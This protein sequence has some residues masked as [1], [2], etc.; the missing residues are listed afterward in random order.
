MLVLL[1]G[2]VLSGAVW[3]FF[4][5]GASIDRVLATNYP[6]VLAAQK[7]RNAVRDEESALLVLAAGDIV[8]GPRLFD[9]AFERAGNSRRE[10]QPLLTDD[11]EQRIFETLLTQDERYQQTA[12]ALVDANRLTPQKGLREAV[13]IDLSPLAVELQASADALEKLNASAI[14][15]ENDQAKEEAERAS[16]VGLGVTVVA[17]VV[18]SLLA[19]RLINMAL[20]PLAL[21]EKQAQ[22]IAQGDLSTK[23]EMPRRDEIGTLADSF[24][25]MATRIAE[26]RTSEARR[27]ERAERMKDAALESLYDP[28][29]VT[30]AK[31]R[32]AHLN[33]AAEDIFGKVPSSPRRPLEEH[34]RDPRVLRAFGH[35]KETNST[36]TNDDER[37]IVP[38]MVSGIERMF[39]LRTTP[40]VAE[41]KLLGTV[42]V[43]EDVTHLRVLDRMKT[44][45]IG[46]AAHELRTPVTSLVLA[47]GLLDEGALG[48]LTPDQK[49]LTS[50]ML[51]DLERL[52]KLMTDLLDV[53]RFE[54][55][56]RPP[57]LAPV[58]PRELIDTAV[59]TVSHV[60][61]EKVVAL[62]AEAEDPL[63]SVMADRSQVGRVL[64]NLVNN[65]IR[66][67]N[68]GGTI[69]VQATAYR[70]HVTF[71]VKDTGEGIPEE[72]R[73]RIFYRFVQV[74][75]ATQGGAGLGLSIAMNIVKAHGGE[76]SVDS[77]VGKG[78]VFQFTL[79]LATHG[80]E[81]PA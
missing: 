71:A 60:A 35:G 38:I 16:Y 15:E 13:N 80:K 10:L 9:D 75:G 57:K 18:A 54:S 11:Q 8:Q 48:D 56:S 17:L 12:N 55:G 74:P 44:E 39:R 79:P 34:I 29:V 21:I 62:R 51:Q 2:V 27:L 66:H 37:A 20:S 50:T 25:I 6:T 81:N 43:L 52:Q 76:M 26:A 40:M 72:Y 41:D 24:N 14:I 59:Q 19:Y 65:A 77:E 78:S 58:S 4:R 7:Y 46:V 63:P 28:V 30:D 49:E 5:L 45:F 22:R 67:T 68:S 64:I 42:A 61:E 1:L 36:T 70:D 3:Q 69:T 31:G 53:T 32:I 23:L 47:T 73:K 33:R